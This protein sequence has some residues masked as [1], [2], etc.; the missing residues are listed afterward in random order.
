MILGS[1]NSM[2]Y[3]PVK[4][5]YFK[6]LFWTVRC[7]SKPLLEQY[8]NGARLFDIRVRFTKSGDLA[9]AHGPIEFKGD[10]HTVLEDL[11]SWAQN[12]KVYVRVILESNS[13]MKDQFLQE[14]HFGYFCEHIQ[15]KYTNLTFFGGNRKYDWKRIY[16]FGTEEPTL[17]DKYSSTTDI[18]GGRPNTLRAKLDDLWP[19]LYAKIHNK[20]TLKN[21][22]DKDVL[23]IDFI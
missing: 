18:F 11:N 15:N 2:T 6:P 10:V 23:F 7:Q 20:N 9:F 19:W 8:W 14:E 12:D 3:L 17:D 21:G 5:W 13:P 16:D 1:H 22:T 4:Q